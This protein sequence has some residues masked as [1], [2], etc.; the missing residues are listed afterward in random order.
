MKTFDDWKTKQDVKYTLVVTVNDEPV[1]TSWYGDPD[2]L[3]EEAR[4]PEAAVAEKLQDEFE[5][6]TKTGRWAEEDE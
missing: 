6:E 1:F 2:N 5:Y 3:Y 4:K